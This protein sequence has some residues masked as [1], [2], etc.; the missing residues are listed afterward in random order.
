MEDVAI[1]PVSPNEGGTR[2]LI[3]SHWRANRDSQFERAARL[4][5]GVI[6]IS[7]YPDEFT[8]VNERVKHHAEASGRDYESMERVFYMTVNL[9]PDSEAATG[10]A[11]RFLKLYYGINIWGERWGPFGAPELAIER[12]RRYQEAGAQTIV[13]RFASFEQENQL[14]TF[15]TE[16]APAFQD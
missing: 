7:D 5:D 6:S 1:A 12:I 3:A 14:D 13:V 15:L 9:N 10:E 4:G 2:V 16:V 11:D 8:Q